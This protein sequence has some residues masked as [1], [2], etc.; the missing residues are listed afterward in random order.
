MQKNMRTRQSSSQ[1]G[2]Q[3]F[4]GLNGSPSRLLFALV[5]LLLAAV[6]A[7]AQ[8][9]YNITS[10]T[11]GTPA[12][13]EVPAGVNGA[14]LTLAGTLP[15]A[16]PISDS[17]IFAC[18]YTGYGPTTPLPLTA[19]G[20][21]TPEKLNVPATVIQA[22]PQEKFTAAN[23]YSV[24]ALVYIILGYDPSY[25]GVCDGT[26]DPAVTNQYPVQ[27]QAPYF[28]TYSGPLAVPQTNPATSLRAA[29]LTLT[30]PASGILPSASTVG[31]T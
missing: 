22:I 28:G 21:A 7:H 20:N 8:S 4:S 2:G 31:T 12:T 11:Y 17:T 13:S 27:V 19:P 30:F 26:Y 9:T 3:F 15:G 18:F 5:V 14:V 23:G 24:T 25:S 29:P 6:G 1:A 16:G 10:A